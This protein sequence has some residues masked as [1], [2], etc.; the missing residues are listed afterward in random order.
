MS[1]EK[2]TLK[3]ELTEVEKEH[4]EALLIRDSGFYISKEKAYS[5]KRDYISA[6]IWKES[7]EISNVLVIKILNG[8]S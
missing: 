4:L 8:I 6:S 1:G 2:F 7:V 5:K 3:V